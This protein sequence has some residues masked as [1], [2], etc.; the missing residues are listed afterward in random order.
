MFFPYLSLIQPFRG[1]EI[2]GVKP[3]FGQ[4]FG[5]EGN[6]AAVQIVAGPLPVLLDALLCWPAAD[7]LLK[8]TACRF[9]LE[10]AIGGEAFA[11][12]DKL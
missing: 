10:L 8:K 2:T 3:A 7:R 1:F 11:K 5:N 9:I 4:A 12:S 6:R